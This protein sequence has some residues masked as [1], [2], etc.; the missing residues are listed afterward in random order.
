MFRTMIVSTLSVVLIGCT[1]GSLAPGSLPTGATSGIYTDADAQ[2]VAACIVTALGSKAQ[3]AGDRIVVASGRSPGTSYNIGPNR[4]SAVYRTQVAI[5]G[6][7][8]D[9][10]E[11]KAVVSCAS[12]GADNGQ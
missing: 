1:G 2:T 10:Q 9:V 8:G 3:P 12:S 7:E 11:A 6:M 4:D 5:T